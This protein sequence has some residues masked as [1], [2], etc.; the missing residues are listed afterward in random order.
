MNSE[1]I[2]SRQTVALGECLRP[3]ASKM[4][5]RMENRPIHSDRVTDTVGLVRH[6]LEQIQANI[7]RFADEVSQLGE[8]L[9]VA[10][11]SEISVYRS[12]ARMEFHLERL[13]DDYDEVR[14][15]TSGYADSDGRRLLE[16]VYR[17][18][19]LQIQGWLDDI[20]ECL[21]DPKGALEKRGLT[22]EQGKLVPIPLD[23]VLEPPPS[24][25]D[26]DRWTVQRGDTL[27]DEEEAILNEASAHMPRRGAGCLGLLATFGLGW[28]LGS[29]GEDGDFDS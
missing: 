7:D 8:L 13:L 11:S 4:R 5:G 6:H 25:A 23:L 12:A 24:L 22:I 10:D 29:A 17:E 28:W 15:A 19:L 26:L 27:I 14:R 3:I 1:S 21:N 16:K 2:L 20:V 18:T 9:E